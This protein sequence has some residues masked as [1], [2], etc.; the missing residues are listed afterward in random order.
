M[1]ALTTVM[2]ILSGLV[3][4]V[5]TSRHAMISREN[6]GALVLTPDAPGAA[7]D[8]PMVSII[9]AAKDEQANLEPCV[10]SLLAQDYPRF[11]VIICDDRSSDGTGAI[12]DRLAAEEPRVRAF[13]IDRLP[14]GWCGKNHAI[15]R[16][17]EAARGEWLC[18]TDADCRWGCPRALSVA[19]RHAADQRAHLLSVLP[20]LE[21]Q[22]L[23]EAIVQPVCSGVMMI[24]FH[25]DKVNDPARPNAYANGAFVLIRRDVYREI[26]THEA[27][28]DKV[29]EDMHLARRVKQAG[30]SLRVVRSHDLYSVRMYRTFGELMRGWCR[31]FLGSFGRLRRLLVS[32]TVLAVMGLLPYAAAVVGFAHAASS[33]SA[34][35]WACGV[36]GAAAVVTQLSVICRYYRLLGERA[37]MALSYPLGCLAAMT[38]VAWAILKLRPG[39]TL[40]WRGTSYAKA[41]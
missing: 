9:V 26:G 24:W 4:L 11:E 7:D 18:T 30:R 39:A 8:A 41:S 22:T 15:V 25:P 13:H 28:R 34:W 2:T 5:W 38:A 33:G 14:E 32:W 31:I 19:M 12:A 40:T 10:R 6:R 23:W 16:G 35:A 21:T 1:L 17:A 27:I 36:A 29:M 3:L 20:V 37:W